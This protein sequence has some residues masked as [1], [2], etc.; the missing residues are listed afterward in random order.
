MIRY[1]QSALRWCVGLESKLNNL[2]LR[3]SVRMLSIITDNRF[4]IIM[5]NILCNNVLT[6]EKH[7]PND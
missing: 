4:N 2:S 3:S 1:M 5:T 7:L 6:Y